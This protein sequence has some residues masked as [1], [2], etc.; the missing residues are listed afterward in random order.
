MAEPISA[1]ESKAAEEAGQNW[2]PEIHRGARRK[3]ITIDLRGATNGEREPVTREEIFDLIRDVRDPEHEEATLEELRVARIEDVHVGESPPYVD[4]FFTPT[5]PHCSMATL[6][7]LCLSVKLLRS[8]PSKFKLRVAIAPGA[9]ASE[10]EINKQLA[11]KER[12]AAALEKI[13]GKPVTF[14][15]DCSGAEVE[16]A[17]A[18]PAPGSVILL[19]NLRYHLEEEGKGVDEAGEK[20]KADKDAVKAFRASL[21]TVRHPALHSCFERLSKFLKVL[22][23]NSRHQKK[24]QE[25]FKE[26]SLCFLTFSLQATFRKLIFGNALHSR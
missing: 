21:R 7:G 4:V 1:A 8:L 11:D 16:A 2:N 20:V 9:H 15:S 13:V 22:S 12:V 23:A 17:C 25:V 5:I 24:K 19:E 10:D 14:L 3:R 26:D 6:I 18:D